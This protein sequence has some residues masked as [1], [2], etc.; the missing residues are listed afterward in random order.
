MFRKRFRKANRTDIKQILRTEFGG[1]TTDA[2][3]QMMAHYYNYGGEDI[4][5]ASYAALED[6]NFHGEAYIN[7]HLA[8]NVHKKD[9]REAIKKTIE[10][11]NKKW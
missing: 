4:L 8:K 11:Y 6:A 1:D 7:Y 10:E 5:N 9:F 2:F 3:G